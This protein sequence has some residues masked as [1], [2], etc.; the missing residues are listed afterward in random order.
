MQLSASVPLTAPPSEKR[1]AAALQHRFFLRLHMAA[2][3][4]ATILVGLGITR[5]LFHLGVMLT[6]RYALAVLAAWGAFIGFVKLWLAYISARSGGS[7]WLDS[8]NFSGGGSSS[9]SESS[10]ASSFGSG[11]GKFGGGGASGSWAEGSAPK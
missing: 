7:D 6:A 8:V 1:L 3:L 5:L 10:S 9:A 4:T 2:I 11:G